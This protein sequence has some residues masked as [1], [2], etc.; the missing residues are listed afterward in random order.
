MS[1]FTMN[2]KWVNQ[3][4]KKRLVKPLEASI[5][6]EVTDYTVGYGKPV[7]PMTPRQIA[8]AID[9]HPNHVRPALRHLIEL[10]YLVESDEG[11]GLSEQATSSVA[12][13]TKSVATKSV[14]PKQRDPLQKATSSVAK[15]GR[16]PAADANPQA[17]IYNLKENSKETPL[18]PG[19]RESI[20]EWFERVW[21][22]LVLRKVGKHSA[23]VIAERANYSDDDRQRI[24]LYL[25]SLNASRPD[26]LSHDLDRQGKKQIEYYPHLRTVLYQRRFIDAVLPGETP[27]DQVP[28]A[29]PALASAPVPVH[30]YADRPWAPLYRPAPGET[31]VNFV[32]SLAAMVERHG[33]A[34]PGETARLF[35]GEGL[36]AA[37]LYLWEHHPRNVKK[38]AAHG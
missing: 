28:P 14:A 19:E 30:P 9:A 4:I 17:P 25:S 24:E 26:W 22:D 35:E 15:R 3:I 18:P 36:E 2:P 7:R 1:G 8:E 5:L 16:K 21:K 34:A 33:T 31:D 20:S 23:W 29:R 37:M 12:E 13:T 11:L 10:G 38:E 6:L 27:G 32:M